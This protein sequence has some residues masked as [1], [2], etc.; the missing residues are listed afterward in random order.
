MSL[1]RSG[2]FAELI[3]GLEDSVGQSLGFV[4]WHA[5]RITS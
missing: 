5:E 4:R 2:P 1:L 3:G